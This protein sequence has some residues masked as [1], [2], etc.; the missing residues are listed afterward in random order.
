MEL[1]KTIYSGNIIHIKTGDHLIYFVNTKWDKHLPAVLEINIKIGHREIRSE[2]M[3][4][5]ELFSARA[6]WFY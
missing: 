1:R 3:K 2:N 4:C 5:I 6:F